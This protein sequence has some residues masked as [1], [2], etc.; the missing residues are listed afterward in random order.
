[1]PNKAKAKTKTKPKAPRPPRTS[2]KPMGR[3]PSHAR[4][5]IL[6]MSERF[7]CIDFWLSCKQFPLTIRAVARSLNSKGKG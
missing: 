4:T 2:M 6:F 5:E 1:M 7:H 3:S